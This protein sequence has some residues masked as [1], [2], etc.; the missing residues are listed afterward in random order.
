MKVTATGPGASA[1]AATGARAARAPSLQSFRIAG[2]Q[3]SAGAGAAQAA[4]GVGGVMGVE[5]L[6]AM[7]DVGSPLER[8]RRSVT[9]AVRILD[10]LDEIK[11]GILEG[12][13]QPGDLDRLRRA[14]RDQR[15]GTDDPALEGVLDEIETRAAV[16]AAKLEMASRAA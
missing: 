13:V 3:P 11:L 14:V 15:A 1:G 16:E 8:R 2:A 12:A 7:Q 9:R 10:V 4:A 5:A 6:I